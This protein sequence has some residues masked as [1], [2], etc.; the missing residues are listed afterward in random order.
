MASTRSITS[1]TDIAECESRI[2]FKALASPL[3]NMDNSYR[4]ALL[5]DGKECG[6]TLPYLL[7]VGVKAKIMREKE[8]T[9]EPL[10]RSIE[11]Q[12][13]HLMATCLSDIHDFAGETED[14]V[15]VSRT[16]HELIF[17]FLIWDEPLIIRS[18]DQLLRKVKQNMSHTVS[19]QN[20]V[21]S[22][23]FPPYLCRWLL[24]K[25]GLNTGMAF[26]TMNPT[27]KSF[28]ADV[29]APLARYDRREWE[30]KTTFSRR[31][32]NALT[33]TA[34]QQAMPYACDML[35]ATPKK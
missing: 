35:F 28:A 7:L 19:R 9:K 20:D 29:Y 24:E 25:D 17:R 2:S 22:T 34:I 32:Q 23:S 16:L 3:M 27:L 26:T 11:K 13:R 8:I 5:K 12:A 30:K 10:D 6:T 18:D 33:Y 4:L 15:L 1:L 31:A 14:D 21:P